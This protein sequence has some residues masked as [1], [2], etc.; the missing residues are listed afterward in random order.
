MQNKFLTMMGFA[1]KSGN[2]MSG[3]NTLELYIPKKKISLVIIA[4]DASENTKSRFVQLSTRFQVPYIIW[5]SRESLSHAI[6]KYNRAVYGISNKKF[7]RELRKIYEE[8]TNSP[9]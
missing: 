8:M 2:L 6:G 3:E 5:G 4:E 9:D 7:S 1:Q